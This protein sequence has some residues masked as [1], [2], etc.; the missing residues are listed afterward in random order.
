MSFAIDQPSSVIE[1]DSLYSMNRAPLPSDT[2]KNYIRPSSRTS[3]AANGIAWNQYHHDNAKRADELIDSN[4]FHSDANENNHNNYGNHVNINIINS[5]ADASHIRRLD[6][7][8]SQSQS[9]SLSQS[10]S[11]SQSQSHIMSMG[12]PKAVLPGVSSFPA[13]ASAPSIPNTSPI[14][15]RLD[16]KPAYNYPHQFP[17]FMQMPTPTTPQQP[18][19]P[20]AKSRNQERI[21]I[22]SLVDQGDDHHDIRQQQHRQNA[23][24]LTSTASAYIVPISPALPAKESSFQNLNVASIV[25]LPINHSSSS[26]SLREFDKDKNRYVEIGTTP[27]ETTRGNNVPGMSMQD[28]TYLADRFVQPQGSCDMDLYHR[29]ASGYPSIRMEQQQQQKQQET[30]KLHAPSGANCLNPTY[31]T[32]PFT[33][34]AAY[35]AGFDPAKSSFA[36]SRYQ[37]QQDLAPFQQQ[38]QQQQ[39]PSQAQIQTSIGGLK[40]PASTALEPELLKRDV[41]APFTLPR[42]PL[43]ARIGNTS[44][45]Q[46]GLASPMHQGSAGAPVGTTT[47]AGAAEDKRF[48]CDECGMV[49]SRR[50]N[51]KVHLRK[52]TGEKPYTCPYPG[53]TKVFRW[54]S[55][56][57]YHLSTHKRPGGPSNNAAATNN[58]CNKN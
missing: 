27:N 28:P 35:R 50:D 53:C 14:L 8:Q 25:P 29:V 3:L 43:S 21:S 4:S 44:N 30:T 40:R 31:S 11:Q 56:M 7:Y 22:F 42:E 34:M 23:A 47:S 51:M 55:S 9:Q 18:L 26:W 37:P 46:N 49:F 16:L 2:G 32:S 41:Q 54:N 5:N 6:S 1:E 20:M 36:G 13:M 39:Q 15:E 58:D 24:V 38:H 17:L 12:M 57:N 48:T 10:L 33:P 45:S 52:H 19:Q